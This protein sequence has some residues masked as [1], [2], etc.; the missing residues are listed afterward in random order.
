MS[1]Q[2]EEGG[3]EKGVRGQIKKEVRWQWGRNGLRM[4][5]LISANWGFAGASDSSE[6]SEPFGC[7]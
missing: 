7:R 5:W 2:P 3:G 4:N 1:E 6:D